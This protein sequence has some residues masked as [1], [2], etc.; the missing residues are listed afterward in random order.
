MSRASKVFLSGVILLSA[1]VFVSAAHAQ[2]PLLHITY[3]FN[4]ALFQEGQTYTITVSVDPS[5]TNLSL[6]AQYP[7]PQPLPTSN[8][9]Q[10][11]LTLPMNIAPGRYS[12]GAIGVT[13]NGDVESAPVQP[14]I[15]RPDSPIRI[16]SEP[17]L[18]SFSSIGQQLPVRTVGT[19]SD[20]ATL[21][22]S[23][24]SSTFGTP[25]NR[26]IVAMSGR[27]IVSALGAGQTR[28]MMQSGSQ[29]PVYFPIV[30]NVRQP[31]LTGPAPAITGATPAS[32]TP[33]A[34]QVTV[35][36][37][38]FGSSQ[39]NGILQI[40]TL[41]A[42]R[43]S[44]WADT[45]IVAT[46]PPGSMTGVVEVDQNGL[47]SNAIRFAGVTPSITGVSPASGAPGTRVTI[48]G[49]NFGSAQGTSTVRFNRAAAL[50][51]SWSGGS[52][53]VPVPANATT[54]NV[55]VMA[56]GTPS[57][58][59]AFTVSPS[60]ASLSPAA[61]AVGA[62]VTVTGSGFGPVQGR[63]TST[64]DGT[65]AVPNIWSATSIAV[66]VPSGA[67]TGAVVAT[68]NGIASNGVTFTVTP[69]N[70]TSWAIPSGT[71]GRSATLPAETSERRK[72]QVTS[73][74]PTPGT[75]GTPV[76]I[77]DTNFGTSQ[78]SRTVKFNGTTADADRLEFDF[79]ESKSAH[80]DD[81]R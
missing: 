80:G 30:V 7:L 4:G 62:A 65:P 68:V 55:L 49:S 11:T 53:V 54:G 33:G 77:T 20:G 14:D 64:F 13:A 43:I 2:Q 19:F 78:G 25:N 72:A 39:G 67:A 31:P 38:G 75:V 5:V 10:F 81:D 32:G 76:T 12:I 44:S 50:P 57:N 42:T 36:G 24:S 51:T 45:Q 74:S 1:V 17:L 70:L 79:N 71:E 66:P 8:P 60:I 16:R 35:T 63:S 41:S 46:M 58:G 6:F 47:A 27:S 21:D 59:V 18:L 28:L 3:P 26:Q 23:N 37:S 48:T 29:P 61:G 56:N 9:T 15:E 34:T 40:G 22:V 69:P 52:I 73:L